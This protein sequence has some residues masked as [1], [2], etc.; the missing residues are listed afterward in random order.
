MF[1]SLS[2]KIYIKC[3][4][5]RKHPNV[6]QKGGWGVGRSVKW[7]NLDEYA[8]HKMLNILVTIW[9]DVW[10]LAFSLPSKAT[11]LPG[12]SFWPFLPFVRHPSL[13]A[14]LL[15]VSM[16]FRSKSKPLSL[17]EASPLSCAWYKAGFNNCLN[18]YLWETPKC[19]PFPIHRGLPLITQTSFL[20]FIHRDQCRK[21]KPPQIF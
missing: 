4:P 19:N 14:L 12:L 8:M 21:Q 2:K 18:R 13:W 10:E 1:Q 6:N 3:L 11:P 17:E 5:H 16:D 15:H 9:F 7:D 20:I